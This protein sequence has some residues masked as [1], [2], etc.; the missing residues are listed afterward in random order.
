MKV[1]LSFI[2]LQFLFSQPN[3]KLP[4]HMPLTTQG[5]K[6]LI[7]EFS[8]DARKDMERKVNIQMSLIKSY[9]SNFP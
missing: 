3:L 1:I 9:M 6:G 8:L 5:K 2:S 4:L 7:V